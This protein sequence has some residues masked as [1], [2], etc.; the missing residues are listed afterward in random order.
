MQVCLW[1][2]LARCLGAERWQQRFSFVGMRLRFELLPIAVLVVGIDLLSWTFGQFIGKD[3][4]ILQ[5]L[6]ALVGILILL[7]VLPLIMVRMWRCRPITDPDLRLLLDE[8][9]RQAQTPVR[10]IYLWPQRNFPFYN[11]MAMGFSKT[12]RVVIISEDLLLGLNPI[13]IQ[14]VI[15]HEL[16][17]LRYHH[18]LKYLVLLITM[19]I[20]AMVLVHSSAVL[21]LDFIPS[22]YE[23]MVQLLLH[24]GCILLGIRFLFGLVSR[25]CER[26]ADLHGAEVASFPAMQSA[27]QKVALLSGQD[28]DTPNWR[29]HSIAQR[30]GYLAQHQYDPAVHSKHRKYIMK[31]STL[32]II[33]LLTALTISIWQN[34]RNVTLEQVRQAD[35]ELNVAIDQA[36]NNHNDEPLFLWLAEQ[37]EFDRQIFVRAADRKT[38]GHLDENSSEQEQMQSLYKHRHLYTPFLKIGTG[39]PNLDIEI[40]N[41]LAYAYSIVPEQEADIESSKAILEKLLPR[42]EKWVGKQKSP[43]KEDTIGCIYFTLGDYDKAAQ[44]FEQA[45]QNLKH[46]ADEKKRPMFKAL[47]DKRIQACRDKAK[48]L[49]V[50]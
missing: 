33:A 46:S 36:L 34:S 6:T 49:P 42:L 39:N 29:H 9:C 13:E 4:P 37:A 5:E 7:C 43:E 22:Q 19:S 24:L 2:V 10:N 3:S 45:K 47:L 41:M 21:W 17:H 32:I 40:D 27:L 44:F 38:F 8:T 23:T 11:A 14:A 18:M 28:L 35:P 26:Q 50:E 16:G 48:Q 20:C 12:F 15:G 30:I 25:A 31:L 1:L